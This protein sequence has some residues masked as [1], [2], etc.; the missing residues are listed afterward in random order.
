MK[1][2]FVCN[3]NKLC[4]PTAKKVF[5]DYANVEVDSTWLMPSAV[6]IIDGQQIAWAYIVFVMD[7]RQLKKIK[8]LFK[9]ELGIEKL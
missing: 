1:V 9:N 3:E 5:A 7:I 2:L 6:K 4:S 8:K